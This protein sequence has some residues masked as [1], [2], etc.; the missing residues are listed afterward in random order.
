MAAARQRVVRR[1]VW[2]RVQLAPETRVP[3][4]PG[5][6]CVAFFLVNATALEVRIAYPLCSV[7]LRFRRDLYGIGVNAFLN[8]PGL[9]A[10]LMIFLR[11]PDL[12]GLSRNIG[13]WR[14][15]TQMNG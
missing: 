8:P 15:G 13:I 1:A 6:A 7:A 10:V 14:S 3:G 12:P 2:N 11:I 5:R 4:L 9:V